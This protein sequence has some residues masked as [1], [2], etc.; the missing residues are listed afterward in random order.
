MDTQRSNR[1]LYD[2]EASN[3]NSQCGE[4]GIVS[5]IL[6]LLGDETNGWC[7]EFGAHDGEH[8]SNTFNLSQNCGYN[9]VLIE[10]D[11][12]RCEATRRRFAESTGVH[13]IEGYVGFDRHD[14]L[15][16]V[17]EQTPIPAEYDFLSIDID[18]NDYHAWEATS[19]YRPKIVCIE[20][21]PTIPTELHY[22]QPKNPACQHGSSIAALVRLGREKGYELV[23]ITP[24]NCLFVQHSL[25][26]RFGIGEN[27]PIVLRPEG[28][29]LTHLFFTYDGECVIQGFGKSPWHRIPLKQSR[30]QPVPWFLRTYPG[31]YTAFQRFLLRWFTRHK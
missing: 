10:G 6:S 25:F 4:D 30:I 21:N 29:P 9:A 2:E 31:K 13:V 26:S 20:Y 18:G 19:A 27:S 14:N 17:L 5:A 23:S 11:Q 22:V 12:E 8:F 28:A 24:L 16:C 15:D 3:V 1:W 7:V